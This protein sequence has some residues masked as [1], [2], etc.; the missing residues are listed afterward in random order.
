MTLHI[1]YFIILITAIPHNYKSD[2]GK[3][4][5]DKNIFDF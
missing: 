2:Y 1:K 3:T 4:F 5:T